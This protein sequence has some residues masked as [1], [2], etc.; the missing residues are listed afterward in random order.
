V[1]KIL[2]LTLHLAVLLLALL[3]A[4]VLVMVPAKM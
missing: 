3:G 1:Q 2:Q 4:V